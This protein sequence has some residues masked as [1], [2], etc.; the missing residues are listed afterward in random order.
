MA[1]VITSYLGGLLTP[2]NGMYQPDVCVN[3]GIDLGQVTTV[4]FSADFEGE[5]FNT[6]WLPSTHTI[7]THN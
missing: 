4:P 7:G 6:P 5:Y 2:S 3:W 1:V